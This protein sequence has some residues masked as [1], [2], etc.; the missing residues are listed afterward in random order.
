MQKAK[1]N[2]LVYYCF[3]LPQRIVAR[4]HMWARGSTG[5][6]Q[7]RAKSSSAGMLGVRIMLLNKMQL[8]YGFHSIW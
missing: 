1:L 3:F 7:G 5:R 6:G 2:I 4:Y 8:S